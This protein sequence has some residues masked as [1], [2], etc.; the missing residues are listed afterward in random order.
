[1]SDRVKRLRIFAGPNGSGKSTLYDYLV[2]IRVFN[3][4]FHINPDIVAR[5]LAVSFNLD[6]WPVDFTEKEIKHFLD[7]SPFQPLVSFALSDAISVCKKSISLKD[8]SFSD[9]R[10]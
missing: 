8:L 2:K 10:E 6:N 5:D 7:V 4:Y 3:S 1:M 9:I